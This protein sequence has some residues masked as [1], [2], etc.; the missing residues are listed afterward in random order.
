MGSNGPWY[1]VVG[2]AENVKNISLNEPDEPEFYWLR[3]N[4]VE[5]WTN[6]RR[7]VIVFS[8][9]LSPEAVAPWVRSQ[10]AHLDPTVPV[11]I[12]LLKSE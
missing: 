11:E 8:T 10:I 6:G 3:R 1:T 12:E 4:I 5:D 7:P 2:V 9:V